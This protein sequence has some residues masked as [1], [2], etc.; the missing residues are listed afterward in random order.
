MALDV[1]WVGTR[2]ALSYHHSSLKLAISRFSLGER[3]RVII[4]VR[5]THEKNRQT[6]QG[7]RET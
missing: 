1:H 5:W 2:R 4:G 7:H 6:E 3:Y